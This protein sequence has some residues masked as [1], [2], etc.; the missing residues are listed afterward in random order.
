[1]FLFRAWERRTKFWQLHYICSV[2]FKKK[3]RRSFENRFSDFAFFAFCNTCRLALGCGWHTFASRSL[4]FTCSTCGF[5][6]KCAG[7]FDTLTV[8]L[9]K[10]KISEEIKTKGLAGFSG[11]GSFRRCDRNNGYYQGFVLCQLC[12]S[13]YSCFYSE[14]A[15]ALCPYSCLGIP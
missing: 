10:I 7:G 6:R 15:T 12:Q 14:I 5:Y 11:S 9:C 3:E 13:L 1:M 8:F 4:N 2:K